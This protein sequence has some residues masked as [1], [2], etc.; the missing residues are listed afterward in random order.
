MKSKR[1]LTLALSV[2]LLLSVCL[3]ATACFGG[4]AYDEQVE[5]ALEL[6]TEAWEEEYEDH[7]ERG[8]DVGDRIKIVNTQVVVL[9]KN[10]FADMGEPFEGAELIVEFEI[11][12]DYY[13][14]NCDYYA[15]NSLMDT[16]VFYENG[17]SEVLQV[18]LL[19]MYGNRTFNYDYSDIIDEVID[20]GDAYN[21][22]IEIN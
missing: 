22:T 16:V 17:S 15:N 9:E 14:H 5:E 1:M 4:S 13:G 21:D 19:R 6:V 10:A 8:I 11:L 7:A 20:L 2:V 3:S 18:D 12:S